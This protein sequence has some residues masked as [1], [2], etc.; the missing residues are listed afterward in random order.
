MIETM[1]NE[2][3]GNYTKKEDQL[4]TAAFGTQKKRRLN[5]V[6]DALGF[7]YPDYEKHDE[8][9]GGGKKKRVVSILKRQAIRSIEEAKHKAISKKQITSA[10]PKLSAPKKQ[11][12]LALGHI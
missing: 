3:L 8:E 12:S 2:I 4:M 7:E 11:K 1:C 9:A 6:M 10:E 5:R